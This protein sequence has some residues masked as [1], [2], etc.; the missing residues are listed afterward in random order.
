MVE[1]R[2]ACKQCGYLTE[3]NKCPICDSNQFADK[4]KGKAIIFN[5]KE[6]FIAD[7]LEIKDNGMFALKY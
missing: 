4:F 1:K 5:A 3:D 2:K 6:S 7:K